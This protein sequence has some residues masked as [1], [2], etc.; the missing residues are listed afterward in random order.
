MKH[1]QRLEME[2]KVDLSKIG[3]V[4]PIF[5]CLYDSLPPVT[6]HLQG[7]SPIKALNRSKK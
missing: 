6:A 2:N 4:P 5:E 1:Y 3:M 7:I